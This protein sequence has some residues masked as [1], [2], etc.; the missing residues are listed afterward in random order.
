[1]QDIKVIESNDGHPLPEQK[2]DIL[3]SSE[4]RL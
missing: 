4:T 1:M 2:C 3:H